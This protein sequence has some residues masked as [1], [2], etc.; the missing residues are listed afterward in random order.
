MWLKSLVSAL[1]LAALARG[2]KTSEDDGEVRSIGLRT[3]SLQQP[4]LDSDMQSRWYD[5]GGDAIIRDRLESDTRDRYIRLT[6][7][8]PSQSGWLFSRVPLTATNWEIEVE[9][10][11]SGKGQLYGDGFAFWVTKNRG[12]MGPVFGAADRFEGLGVF[13]DTYKN[14]RPGVVFPYVMA[15]H[16]DGQTPY[17]KDNDGKASELAGCSARGIR[18]AAVPSRFKLTYFQDK[19]LKLE[20]Q[21]KSEGDWQ[22]CFETRQPP[23]LP[24]IA[25]LGFSA[26][27]GELHDN[28]DIISVAAKNLYTAPGKNKNPSTPG[29]G[30]S[31]SRGPA[32][33]KEGGSWTWFFGKIILF[34]L[35]LGAAYVGYTAWRAK[36]DKRHR[37]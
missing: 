13:F 27:T 17:D 16:G 1:G 15:M 22:L 37:F 28:H 14:N 20:L 34:I 10:K 23:A 8:R 19:L 7:D 5:F 3:H 36:N 6:S 35:V 18:N 4:Y 25:Y 2:Q 29:S 26:E 12:Q 33:V 11:I 32:P 9:F 30:Q 31:S 21:Y 24:S